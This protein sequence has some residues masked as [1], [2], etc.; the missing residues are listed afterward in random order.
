[1]SR[2]RA[3]CRTLQALQARESERERRAFSPA[4]APEPERL[5]SSSSPES[6]VALGVCVDRQPERRERDNQQVSKWEFEEIHSKYLHR[7]VAVT[8]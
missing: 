6:S 5:E 2:P 8:S 7:A 3:E 4:F 1:M